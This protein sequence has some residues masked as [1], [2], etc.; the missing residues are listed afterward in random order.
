M[1]DPETWARVSLRITCKSLAVSQLDA[2][3][4]RRSD[5]R[6]DAFWIADLVKD[7]AV[8][9]DAQLRLAEDFLRDKEH[10]LVQLVD[11]EINLLISWTPHAPQDGIQLD[12]D[13]ISLLYRTRCYVLLDTH[14]D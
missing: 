1:G 10:A 14:L 5:A 11:E 13:L 4:G 9:L 7:S 12:L 2:L 6:S 3:L 8:R